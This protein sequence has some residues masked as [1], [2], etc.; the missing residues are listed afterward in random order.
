MGAGKSTPNEDEVVVTPCNVRESLQRCPTCSSVLHIVQ[1]TDW[2][3][4]PVT[5]CINCPT[6][7]YLCATCFSPWQGSPGVLGHCANKRC[8]V[9]GNLLTCGLITDPNSPVKGC[10]EFRACPKCYCLLMH[11]NKGCNNVTC[12]QCHHD[13]CYICLSSEECDTHSKPAAR[14]RFHM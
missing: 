10:P 1:G 8:A 5:Q 13:F 11:N 2:Q 7:P 9:V 6:K 12:L 4:S 3:A 14:Q